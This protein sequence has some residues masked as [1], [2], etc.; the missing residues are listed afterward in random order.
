[1]L[2]QPIRIAPDARQRIQDSLT[3]PSLAGR[4]GLRVG[5]RGGGCGA[6]WLLGFDE[7][8]STDEIYTIDGVQVIIDRRHLL[9]VLGVEIGYGLTDGQ[10]GFTIMKA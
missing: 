5:V 10:P 3:N 9:Y 2:D 8:S 7:P 4:Y 6:A 1:M